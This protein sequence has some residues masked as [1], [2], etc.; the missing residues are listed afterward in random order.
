MKTRTF[1]LSPSLLCAMLPLWQLPSVAQAPTGKRAIVREEVH[2]YQWPRF[3]RTDK[4]Y[5]ADVPIRYAQIMALQ[6]LLRNRGFF[7]TMPDG[8]FGVGTERAVKRFQKA[9]KIVADGVIGE[10]TFAR[11]IVRLR[12]GDR[13]HAV[14]ALQLLLAAANDNADE[15][16]IDGIFGDQTSSE[17]H[18][19]QQRAGITADGIAGPQTWSALLRTHFGEYAVE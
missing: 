13:G 1:L 9:Q 7:S 17:L 11:L 3:A 14:R 10:Q 2:R 12:R 6:Y 4:V 8:E 5:N 16:S 18:T 19:F 15:V